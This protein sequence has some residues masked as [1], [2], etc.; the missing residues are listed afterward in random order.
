MTNFSLTAQQQ[1]LEKIYGKSSTAHYL[2]AKFTQE[3]KAML[4]WM[5]HHLTQ[6]NEPRI[7]IRHDAQ[8]SPQFHAYDPR[9]QKRFYGDSE[10]DLRV[11][12][13]ARY[14]G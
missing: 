11:W 10:Q 2:S 9:T 8:G 5:I 7:W 4:A 14:S 1:K 12:L 13:E 6:A 3:F